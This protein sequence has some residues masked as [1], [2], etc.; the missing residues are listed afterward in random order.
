MVV[1]RIG[2]R[3]NVPSSRLLARFYAQSVQHARTA[4]RPS[5][6]SPSG[7]PM[8]TSKLPHG[9]RQ[10]GP[11]TPSRGK[12]Q[13]RSKN[14][15][16]L[17]V[18]V[19]QVHDER[20]M[21]LN[22]PPIVL[23][24]DFVLPINALNAFFQQ[25]FSLKFQPTCSEVLIA[26][27][28][29]RTGPKYFRATF[30][31]PL[32]FTSFQFDAIGDGLSVGAAKSNAARHAIIQLY[33]A[34]MWGKKFK[35]VVASQGP[36]LSDG[37]TLIEDDA[38][39][40]IDYYC[41]SFGF[42]WPEINANSLGSYWECVITISGRRLGIGSGPS[43]KFAESQAYLDTALY[44]ESCDPPLWVQFKAAQAAGKELGLAPAVP[45]DLPRDL[46]GDMKDLCD[47]ELS[48]KSQLL[49]DTLNLYYQNPKLEKMREA[50]ATLPVYTR[51]QEVLDHVDENDVS[52]LMA[53]TGSGKTTQIPQLILDQWTKKGEGAKCNVICTQPRRLAAIS[54]ATRVAAERGEPL[55]RSIGYTVRFESKPPQQ[56]GSVS[57]CTVGIFLKKL[58][59]QLEGHTN[60]LDNVTHIVVDEVHER[61]IDTDLLLVVLKRL[62]AH[63]KAQGKPLKVVLMS[64]TIDPTL[65]HL[66]RVISIPG[67]SFPVT[68]NYL[69][70]FL[71]Q[72]QSQFPWVFRNSLVQKYIAAETTPQLSAPIVT[73]EDD[74]DSSTP[75]SRDHD[76]ELPPALVAA[77][78][79]HVMQKTDEGHC[80]VFLGGWEEISGVQKVLEKPDGPLGLNFADSSKYSL[81][82]LHSSIPL[83]EQQTIFDPAPPGV[84]R[85]IL[86]T[87]IAET[88]VTIPDVV[89]VVDSARVKETRYNPVRHVTAL[90]SAWVGR[91][92]L[93]QRAGRA[94]RHRPG[95]Y[96][97]L[98]TKSH[99]DALAPNQTVEMKRVDL[100]NVIMHIKALNFT[101]MTIEEALEQTIEPPEPT[102]ISSAI[103][104]LVMVGALTEEKDLTSL[105][106]VLLKIPIDVQLGRLVLFGSFFRCLD[107]ALTLA[108]LLSA[109]DPFVQ[110]RAL[111]KQARAAKHRYATED[112][113]SDTLAALLAFEKWWEL[114][115]S[116]RLH[117]ANSYCIEN[118]LSKPTLLMA[119]K[120]KEQLLGTLNREGILKISGGGGVATVD[121]FGRATIPSALNANGDNLPLL[122]SLVTLATQ[123][124]VAVRVGNQYRTPRD[125]NVMVGQG[126]VNHGKD[127]IPR[128]GERQ[129]IVYSESR[130]NLTG[131]NEKPQ[132]TLAGTTRIDPLIYLLFSAREA[133]AVRRGLECDEWLPIAGP[134]TALDTIWTLRKLIDVCMYRVWEG[135]LND[136]GSQPQRLKGAGGRPRWRDE[137]EWDNDEEDSNR[138][139]E[140]SVAEVQELD[141]LTR[142]I[143]S[144]L[145]RFAISTGHRASL[146]ESYNPPRKQNR[147]GFLRSQSTY[148]SPAGSRASSPFHSQTRPSTPASARAW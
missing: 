91:S 40:F 77:A 26:S 120:V 75:S 107:R 102:N 51:I 88:S 86:S 48:A 130:V 113:R 115:S 55:G 43:K 61:D 119:A 147:P 133:K 141:F 103:K 35:E 52:I 60:D 6:W 109:R 110:P 58:Q 18:I 2:L 49:T 121:D 129:L 108:S 4:A 146:H 32:P 25:G 17:P 104:N 148:P 20:F 45:L 73:E 101:N 134:D 65:F 83:A 85:I 54:V 124:R 31:Q 59:N 10:R 81:H 9:G 138:R 62:M 112:Y 143:V 30:Q 127:D 76:T 145:A 47:E 93:F 128:A 131:G 53:A 15:P 105:G 92:N 99:V 144:M 5:H 132:M 118:F 79:S 12:Q 37:S 7:T 57:F 78:I 89:Y 63:R 123:P 82:I 50:R 1:G 21:T 39:L 68:H 36:S 22:K 16:R 29:G 137:D 14:T 135:V 106:R 69:D 42:Q 71:P 74:D 38:R 116:G 46:V 72:L 94:G 111:K 23:P 114:Q 84:R 19:S 100:S 28:E 24:D 33:N 139:Q 44:I 142:D 70:D 80:L 8:S 125:K 56:N 98:L 97:G 13:H 41:R 126:S 117:E 3:L 90:V 67:R 95:E 27:E 136:K 11:P 34:G 122:A 64:A 87:N 140:L 96:Y 66:P